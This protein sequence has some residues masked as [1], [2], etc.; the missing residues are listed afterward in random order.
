MT[1]KICSICGEGKLTPKEAQTELF[2]NGQTES[3]PYYYSVCDVCGSEQAGSEELR[4]NKRIALDFR[5]KAMG[6][7]R[8]EEIRAIREDLHLN[9]KKASQIFGGGPVAFSKYENSDVVQSEAMDKLL[10]VA[11]SVPEALEFLIKESS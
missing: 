9:Q 1:Q 11:H 10:R 8:G 5:R 3:A 4:R 7:L 2:Y 6:L